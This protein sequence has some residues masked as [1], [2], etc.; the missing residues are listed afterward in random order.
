MRL[1][2]LNSRS[3]LPV[4]IHIYDL[5][6]QNEYLYPLGMIFNEFDINYVIFLFF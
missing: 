5:H 1:T 6:P 3:N 2:S 4:I